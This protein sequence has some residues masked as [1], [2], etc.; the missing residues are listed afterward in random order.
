[1][2]VLM[3]SVLTC[4]SETWTLSKIDERRLS[5]F[6]T[7]VLRC[8]FGTKQENGVW[9]ERYNHELFKTFNEPNVVNYIKVKT[10]VLAGHM[11]HMK[12]GRILKKD[13]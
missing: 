7:E 9:Q 1:M 13:I 4:A 12:C 6:E 3:R 2:K 11:A 8:I 10:L 5:L